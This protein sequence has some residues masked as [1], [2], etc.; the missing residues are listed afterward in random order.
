M[1][2]VVNLFRI[3]TIGSLSSLVNSKWGTLFLSKYLTT[4]HIR[5]TKIKFC[6]TYQEI[7]KQEVKEELWCQTGT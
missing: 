3:I 1:R 7:L 5:V 2:G 4:T 6:K